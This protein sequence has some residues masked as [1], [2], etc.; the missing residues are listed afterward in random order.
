MDDVVIYGPRGNRPRVATL[1]INLKN[2]PADQVGA[3]LDADYYVCVRAGLH[4]AP[5][6]HVDEGTLEQMGAVRFA[7]GYF[8]DDEDLEQAITGVAELME[9]P[10]PA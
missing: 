7:P 6:V 10:A 1:S 2:L 3:M 4:C 8:T 9:I 5:L